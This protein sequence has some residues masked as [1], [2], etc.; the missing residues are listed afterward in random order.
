MTLN[1]HLIKLSEY[2]VGFNMYEG[3]I[4]VNVLYPKKW[5][6]LKPMS[7]NINITDDKGRQYYWANLADIN[8]LFDLIYDT[9][10]YNKAIEE[11]AK[12]FKEKI[13]EMQQL[14]INEDLDVLKTLEFKIKKKKSTPKS[15]AKKETETNE[16][17]QQEE[18]TV[19]NEIQYNDMENLKE[20][21]VEEGNKEEEVVTEP[22]ENDLKI[23]EAVAEMNNETK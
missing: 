2:S 4:I 7:E 9:I 6:I 1:E 11:K 15:K 17:I 14:F 21:T 16:E 18:A 22:T 12:L 5:S 23:A 19:E 20:E 8:E 3:T 10:D 13:N